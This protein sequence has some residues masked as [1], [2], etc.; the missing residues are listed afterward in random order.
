MSSQMLPPASETATAVAATSTS[1]AATN[2]TMVDE[3]LHY[4]IHSALITLEFGVTISGARFPPSTV[5]PLPILLLH[6]V[7]LVLRI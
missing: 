4:L 2:N 1:E 3:N 6:F 5:P 7:A